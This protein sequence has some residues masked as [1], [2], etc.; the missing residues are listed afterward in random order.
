M[1]V[2]A[3]GLASRRVLACSSHFEKERGAERLHIE[4]QQ[5]R[6]GHEQ[7]PRRHQLARREVVC[8]ARG[9]DEGVG[10]DGCGAA[11]GCVKGAQQRL[12]SEECGHDS[13]LQIRP[14]CCCCELL[15]VD[16]QNINN[17]ARNMRVAHSFMTG[18]N[19]PPPCARAF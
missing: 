7:E 12:V 4:P 5:P 11:G 13:I 9:G 16:G 3:R 10:H 15:C 1:G 8:G 14:V 19:A 2:G 18:L 6:V 17:A